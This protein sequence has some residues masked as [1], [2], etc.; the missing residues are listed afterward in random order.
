MGELIEAPPL[1]GV[2]GDERIEIHANSL[3]RFPHSLTVVLTVR[4]TVAPLAADEAPAV[5]HLV[6][7]DAV[8]MDVRIA[9]LGSRALA[10]LLDLCIQVGLA[11]LLVIV[12]TLVLGTAGSLD[13]ATVSVVVVI[14]IVV[15]LI[16]YPV[17]METFARGRTFGKL[18]MG[19]RVVRD[20]GGPI[21]FR[22][23][24]AR[25]LVGLSAEV[26][27]L[28]PP[29]TWFACVGSMFA[30]PSGKR[31]G[32]IAAGTIVIHERT[33]QTWGWVPAM[34]PEL[35]PWARLL[36]LT[37]LSDDLA[38]AV[39]NYLSRNRRLREPARTRLGAELA[40]EVASCVR[41]PAP[42]GT[43][44]WAYLAAVLAERH[45]RSLARQTRARAVTATVWPELARLTAAP[46]GWMPPPQVPP[47]LSP[48]VPAGAP[49][50]IRP[51]APYS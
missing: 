29:L 19:L 25:A 51:A 22:Q 13:E 28:M 17:I 35:E 5:G 41:P 16:G 8:L 36:D 15:V 4:V 34:P 45:R 33:P 11:I 21:R 14:D 3:A 32:D 48:Q 37:R 9:R 12:G 23:A 50:P 38:L 24:L 47:H 26:P 49:S 40:A 10:R 20:D 42:P 1:G 39:R 18:A 6:T 30:S 31:L 46:A 43:A 7:G 27:G 2:F 44:G